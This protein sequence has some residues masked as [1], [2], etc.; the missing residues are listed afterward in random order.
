MVVM[1]EPLRFSARPRHAHSRLLRHPFSSTVT[2]PY[3]FFFTV[4]AQ[5]VDERFLV[6]VNDLLTS[7]VIPDLFTKEEFD[8]IF[9]AIRI[10]AKSAGVPDVRDSLMQFFVDRYRLAGAQRSGYNK[11]VG[12]FGVGKS[13]TGRGVGKSSR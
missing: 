7:G 8:S 2:T 6:Y 11:V 9:Q 5:I 1:R 12:C 13:H 3:V 10:A 4:F